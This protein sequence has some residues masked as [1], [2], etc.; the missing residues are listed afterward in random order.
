MGEMMGG[1]GDSGI[2]RV[3]QIPPCV[4]KLISEG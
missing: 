2:I 4:E 3:V 1:G